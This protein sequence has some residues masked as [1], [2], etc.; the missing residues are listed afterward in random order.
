M[1]VDSIDL[2]SRILY[3]I[4]IFLYFFSNLIVRFKIIFL[5]LLKIF[6]VLEY[7]A[8]TVYLCGNRLK[9]EKVGCSTVV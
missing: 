2:S 8:S 3:W 7:V 6:E 5:E 1:K 9:G 4:E